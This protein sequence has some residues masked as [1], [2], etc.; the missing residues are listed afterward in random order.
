[1]KKF[2]FQSIFIFIFPF[3]LIIYSINYV[4]NFPTKYTIDKGTNHVLVKWNEIKNPNEQFDNIILGSSR[5]Y[6]AYNPKI[7][8]S[9]TSNSTYNMATSSQNIIESYYVLKEV[10]KYQSPKKIIYEIFVPQFTNTDF[11]HIMLN[12]HF[13]SN[14]GKWDMILNGYHQKGLTNIF[15]P[16]LKHKPYLKNE[17]TS[18]FNLM[19]SS[20]QNI[21]NTGS[22][23]S[24]NRYLIKGYMYDNFIIDSI[25]ASKMGPLTYNIDDSL[26]IFIKEK[27]ELIIKLCNENNIELICV[28]APYPRTRINRTLEDKSSIFFTNFLDIKG[29]PFY[30][31]NYYKNNN[32]YDSDFT[33][34]HHINSKGASK[35]SK[36]LGEI[37]KELNQ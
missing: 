31:F 24:K 23:I 28:R 1:M 9:I 18:V 22:N 20:T 32:F 27:L 37:L 16:L 5:A 7:I 3:I 8:D 15:N 25:Q 4:L 14:Q 13:M 10:L 17:I 12:A 33:D 11:Y 35:V 6:N 21:S 2:I 30:D 29:I 19:K 34:H 26:A 36:K